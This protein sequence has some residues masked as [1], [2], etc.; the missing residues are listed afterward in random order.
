MTAP[1]DFSISWDAPIVPS[2]SLAGIPLRVN[3]DVL[4]HALSKYV[5]DGEDSIY[6][7]ENSPILRLKFYNL[8]EKGD[9]GYSFVL[10]NSK[11]VNKLK[12]MTPALTIMMKGGEVYAIKVYDFSFPSEPDHEFVYKGKLPS[13]ICLG[14]LVS[15]LLPFTS[16]EF[17]RA[18]S[19]FYTDANYGGLEVS[20]WGVPLE[21]HPDQII[22]SLC[23]IAGNAS[24]Y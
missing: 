21:H 24:E 7:F 5:I 16:L 1:K 6:Q 20:G 23:V 4:K 13:G 8:D 9:G 18:E 10:P 11:L 17:D 2:V 3:A 19:W 14:S 12:H 22:T 15:D